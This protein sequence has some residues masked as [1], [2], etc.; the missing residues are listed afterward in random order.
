MNLH[1]LGRSGLATTR[2]GLG[3][4]AL[5]RPGYINLGHASDLKRT[6]E[7]EAMR[8]HAYSVLDAAWEAGIRYFD[9]ARSYGMAESFLGSWLHQRGI[10]PGAITVG[11]KWGYVY[12]AEWRVDAPVHEVKQ[13]TLE[14]LHRQRRETEENLGS[15][16]NLYQIHSA[17]LDSGVLA[18]RDVIDELARYRDGGLSIGLTVSGSR[19]W[20]LKPEDNPSLPAS[21]R[22]GICSRLRLVPYCKRR[23]PREW[24]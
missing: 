19:H 12:T 23:I 2:I 20:R 1:P 4:A 13:H 9:V 7:V 6:Y 15:Y 24:V 17:T 8:M 18:N 14:V 21:R 16:V 11:S 3:L 5:G 22:P 10:A